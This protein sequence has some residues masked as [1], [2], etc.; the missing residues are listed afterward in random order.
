MKTLT[1]HCVDNSTKS[2]RFFS[3]ISDFLQQSILLSIINEDFDMMHVCEPESVR[4]HA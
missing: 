1:N 3:V 4:P 2:H